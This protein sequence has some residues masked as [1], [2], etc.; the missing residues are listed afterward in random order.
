MKD[1]IEIAIRET[2]VIENSQS[3]GI[4]VDKIMKI[5]AKKDEA[6]KTAQNG[7]KDI[8]IAEYAKGN[9]IIQT[10]EGAHVMPLKE[11]IKQPVDGI[12]YDLNRNEAVILTFIDDPKWVN[13]YAMC[14][15]IREL[16][17]MVGDERN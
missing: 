14:K 15:V 9:V 3:L 8:V 4:A 17:S 1:K 2:L 6:R 7:I 10:I 11:F 13:D 12:L 16:K 5:I